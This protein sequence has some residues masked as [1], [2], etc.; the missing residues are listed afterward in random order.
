[1]QLGPGGEGGG[2]GGGVRGAKRPRTLSP[3]YAMVTCLNFGYGDG[4][5]E[6]RKLDAWGRRS[7]GQN[8]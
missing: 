7:V 4:V 1:M 5:G 2:G 8:V 6:C 3:R